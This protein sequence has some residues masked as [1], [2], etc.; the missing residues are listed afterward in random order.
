MA[1]HPTTENPGRVRGITFALSKSLASKKIVQLPSH[2]SEVLPLVIHSTEEQAPGC[3]PQSVGLAQA[4]PMDSISQ[5]KDW[6]ETCRQTLLKDTF[7]N[8]N[9]VSWAG[10]HSF[11][12]SLSSQ[13]PAIIALLPMFIENAHSYAMIAH[14]IKVVREAIHHLNPSKTPVIAVDQLLFALAKQIQWSLDGMYSEDNLVVILGGLHIDMAALK[15]V[16]KWL[17]GISASHLAR[18]RRAHQVTAGSLYALMTK[19]YDKYADQQTTDS[20]SFMEWRNEM[21]SK[22]PQFLYWSTVLELEVLCLQFVRAIREGNFDLYVKAI[23]PL[24]SWFF[25]LDCQN[26]VKWLSIHYRDMCQLKEKHP[27]VCTAFNQG[28]F[29]VHKTK[30]TLL[31]DCVGPCT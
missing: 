20:K 13:Q 29:V 18:T 17:D 21:K 28:P 1:Q 23:R 2:Y 30:K 4:K 3:T 12:V 27:S 24:L 16:G 15:A 5:E 9:V 31:S 10:Y 26:Y 7:G 19:A 11:H 14:S 6:L 22:L 8:K 25:C